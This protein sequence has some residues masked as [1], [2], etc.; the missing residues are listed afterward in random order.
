MNP[1]RDQT[2]D[3][4]AGLGEFVKVKRYLIPLKDEWTLSNPA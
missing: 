4:S 3:Y 2:F 1:V